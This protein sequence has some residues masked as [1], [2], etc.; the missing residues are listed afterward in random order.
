MQGW[1]DFF[2]HWPFSIIFKVLG[3][4]YIPG[5]RGVKF[6]L[7]ISLQICENPKRF[8]K[9]SS[10]MSFFGLKSQ[11]FLKNCEWGIVYFKFKGRKKSLEGR[12]LAMS[13]IDAHRLKI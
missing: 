5:G 12:T 13:A 10:K 9:H 2:I 8:Q 3:P 7:K 4:Q 11:I 1:P 6:F